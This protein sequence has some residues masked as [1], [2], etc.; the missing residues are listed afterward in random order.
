MSSRV[1]PRDLALVTGASGGIG[2]D[3]ARVLARNGHDLALVARNGAALD[4]LA[5]EIAVAGMPRPLV[6]ARDLA[7]PG[8]AAE[9][10]AALAA[11]NARAAI[12][13]NNAG[14]GLAGQARDL[15]AGEQIEMIDLNIGA[16]AGLTLRLL[17]GVIAARGK[18]L[19][20]ASVVAFMPGPGFAVYSA[21]KAFVVSFSEALSAELAGAGVTVTVLCPGMTRTG[22]HQ[23]AGIDAAR[24][25]AFAGM[26]AM[27]VAEAGYAGMMAG[28]RRVV[29]GAANKIL[30][31]VLPLVPNAMLLPLLARYQARRRTP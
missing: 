29:P 4:E 17:P 20:V 10:A 15:D 23:R 27:R 18:I 25:P 26:S 9:L 7:L 6:L 8:A 16:L 22:F 5:D 28:R 30:T 21:T 12:L 3:L 13:V 31:S 14:F 1:S 24:V 19:N 11:A 2:A